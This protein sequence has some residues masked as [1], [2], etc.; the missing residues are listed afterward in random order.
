MTTA[1]TFQPTDSFATFGSYLRFLR[2]RA[3]LTQRELA[4]AVNYSEGQI[5]HLERDRRVPDLATLAALFVPALQLEEAPKESA[6]LLALAAQNNRYAEQATL[7]GAAGLPTLSLPLIGRAQQRVALRR[8]LTAS[9]IRLLTL[10]GPPGVGKTHLA[11]QLAEDVRAAFRDGV[12]FVDLSALVDADLVMTRL[13][14]ALDLGEASYQQPLPALQQAL[15]E[16]HAL[17]IL[18][19]FEQVVEAATQLNHLLR[20]A[21]QLRLLVTS[22]VTL[23]LRAEHVVVVPPLAVPDLAPA[24]AVVGAGSGGSSSA[25]ARPAAC[26]SSGAGANRDQCAAAGR[27]LCA[28]RRPAASDRVNR[29]ARAAA[30]PAGTL[31]RSGAAVSAFAPARARCAAA[32]RDAGSGAGLELRATFTRSAATLCASQRFWWPLASRRCRAGLRYGGGGASCCVGSARRIARTQSAPALGA[33]RRY[34]AWYAGD[35]TR[36]RPAAIEPARRKCPCSH[37][38]ACRKHCLCRGGR[39]EAAVGGRPGAVDGA[40]GRR[41]R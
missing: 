23:R 32:P 21:P 7:P 22:R 26:G 33:R 35:G 31:E 19:N 14:Q 4:V 20:A 24:A 34:A 17:I 30:Q 11:Q 40:A 8:L 37:T 12:Y 2:R 15:A 5:C 16:R 25:A 9:D 27:D 41:T 1:H 18:D 29:L 28:R 36:V 13:A 6:R 38:A 3:R 39:G 10:N